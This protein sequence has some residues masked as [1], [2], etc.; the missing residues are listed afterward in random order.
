MSA[1]PNPPLVNVSAMDS[2]SIVATWTTP[3][4]GKSASLLTY[5]LRYRQKAGNSVDWIEVSNHNPRT[6]L[7][8]PQHGCVI[9][10]VG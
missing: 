6:L 2:H 5:K 7:Q 8:A 10:F 3:E 9:I 4:W 1:I